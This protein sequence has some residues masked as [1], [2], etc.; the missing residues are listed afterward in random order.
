MT[1]VELATR[2]Q[3]YLNN[4]VY[5]QGYDLNDSI[6]D[7]IDEVVAF[8]G[9]VYKSATISFTQYTTYY[10][11][12]NIL[13]D[14]IGVVAIFNN[15]IKRFLYPTSLKKLNQTRID[16]DT[17]YGVP[18]YFVPISHRYVAI[19]QKP[20]VI[21]YGNMF[22]YYIAQA[23]TL[24]DSTQIPIPDE[25]ITALENYIINDLNEQAQE[26][27]KCQELF[28]NYTNNLKSLRD[29]MKSK[30]NSDRFMDLKY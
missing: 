17:V 2:I 18:Y 24:D 23:P 12:L 25:H 20:S 26:F 7:G 29:L 30:R 5:Y 1:R 8:S 9:C 27:G 13:P 22:V 3:N 14:Y 16:W 6:Q 28:P 15:P 4:T 21:N 10:D 11:M 19:F